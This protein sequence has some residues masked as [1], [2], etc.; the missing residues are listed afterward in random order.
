MTA[1]STSPRQFKVSLRNVRL[2]HAGQAWKSEWF[3]GRRVFTADEVIAIRK[4]RGKVQALDVAVQ[5]KANRSQIERIMGLKSYL[6]VPESA[7]EA[8]AS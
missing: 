3:R 2:I 5:F 8:S 6:W 4:L 7:D 1:R